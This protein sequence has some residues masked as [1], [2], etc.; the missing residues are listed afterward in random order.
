MSKTKKILFLHQNFPGQYKHLAPALAAEKNLECIS[1]SQNPSGLDG[2]KHYQY[3]INEGNI[4]NVNR[5]VTE[6]ETKMIRINTNHC[7]DHN[8]RK[9]KNSNFL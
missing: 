6:F 4:P 9:N 8:Q 2:I 7:L 3:E 5:L 1:V